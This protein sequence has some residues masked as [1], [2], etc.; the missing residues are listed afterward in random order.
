MAT[1]S[2]GPSGDLTSQI[3]LALSVKEPVLS[4]EYFPEFQFAD[5]KAA[6]DRLAS[7][8]MVK[9]ESIERE[10]AVLEA[11]GK[12]IAEHGSHEARVFEA[13]RK[14]LEGLTIQELEA[15]IGDKNVTKL[16]QGKAFKNKWVKKEATGKLVATTESIQDETQAQLKEIQEKHTHDSKVITDLK[17][18]KLIKTQKVITFKIQKGP[19]FALEIKKEETDL[20]A[21]MIASGSWKTANFKPYNFKALGADQNAGALH[22][23]NKVR[24]EFRQIF[25]EMGFEEMPTSKFVESGFWNF[26]ALFVPQQHP[27][28]DLQ[29]TFYISDPKVADKP[30]PE[31]ADDKKDYETYWE[32]VKQ[33]HQDGKF[34]SIGYRYPWAADEAQRLV[35]RTHTTAIS[36]AVLHQLAAKKGP[37]GR[38]PPARY[39][40][41]DR[42]FRNE[43]VDATHLAEFHQVEGVI[44]DYGLTL[45][46]LM[47]FMEIFFNK[48]GITDIKF[49]PAYNPYTEP[50]MEIFSFH[51][52]LNK[53]VEIGNSG[54]FRPEMLEAMGL[55]KD[56]RVYGW[57]LSLERPTMIKYGISNIR[58]L[59]GHK[60]DLNFIE[61]N[62]AVR[63]E[64]N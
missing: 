19:E 39:F 23:L 37:D 56:M 47:E 36:T 40:S 53:L 15:A 3:L 52:G 26:D 28:R 25:F 58:E 33:V 20:T 59:L 44:A 55:P 1:A 12:Q 7:R 8:S 62:P 17:K 38:P 18:R 29:D 43:S 63:L 46:G 27:A 13:V 9:Y 10:E 41:I 2:N 6:L 24:H 57:G 61:R 50:S 64:K 31:S 60:V 49:K 32:N 22:P 51:K 4:A 54:M 42:V 45:G 5:L 21:D 35:L 11:E 16:G 14:A 34:G 48:M 30:G